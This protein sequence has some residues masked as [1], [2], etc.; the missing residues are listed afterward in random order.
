MRFLDTLESLAKGAALG[1]VVITGLPVFGP[2]GTITATGALA[3]SVIGA[4][5]ALADNLADD[6]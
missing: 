5:A 1:V 2:I 4:A 3:G 6:D